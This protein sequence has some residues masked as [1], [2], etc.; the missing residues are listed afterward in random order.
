MVT[1]KTFSAKQHDKDDR[2]AKVVVAGF[3][4]Q[5]WG[6]IVLEGE[7]YDADLVCYRDGDLKGFV[8]VERRHNWVE[9]FPFPTVH[10]PA[11]KKKFFMLDKPTTL[12]SVRS[13]LKKALWCPGE[14]ILSSPI[15][16][17]KN[18]HC[19]SEDFFVVPLDKWKLTDL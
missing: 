6:L 11:R 19:D 15:E 3:L 7:Q 2:P 18:K 4:V 12:F 17:L 1:R 8:E 5:N 9:D 14:V 13:D 10:V 16:I